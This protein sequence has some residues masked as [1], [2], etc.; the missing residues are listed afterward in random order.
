MDYEDD[1]VL[2]GSPEDVDFHEDMGLDEI[3]SRTQLMS[4]SNMDLTLPDVNFDPH[5]PLTNPDSAELSTAANSIDQFQF[6]PQLN[7]DNIG[8]SG[9]TEEHPSSGLASRPHSS[10]EG[11]ASQGPTPT[12]RSHESDL[13]RDTVT[14]DVEEAGTTQV[15]GS[16]GPQ[17][18]ILTDEDDLVILEERSSPA[19]KKEAT[20]DDTEPSKHVSKDAAVEV[21][22]ISDS[23]SDMEEPEELQQTTSHDVVRPELAAS[24]INLGTKAFL[25]TPNPKA[26]RTPAQMALMFEAQRRLAQQAT[27]RTVTG[28]ATSIF[29]GLR[30]A[31]G[32]SIAGPSISI[33][34]TANPRL[35]TTEE[36]EHAWMLNELSDSDTDAAAM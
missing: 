24:S 25:R 22:V 26:R 1:P 32:Q 34:E 11:S 7:T 29:G 33:P 13:T 30:E 17:A 8:R 27:G 15:D 35:Q 18:T 3:L 5:L 19:V 36:D 9:S 31:A 4:Q 2:G 23:D 28:G 12:Q 20:D 21:I 14:V 10:E 16:G 6:E